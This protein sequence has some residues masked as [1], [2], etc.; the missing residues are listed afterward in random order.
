MR[1]SLLLACAAC[2]GPSIQNPAPNPTP[3]PGPAPASSPAALP[4]LAIVSSAELVAPG[5]VS[6][7][8]VEIRLAASPDGNTLLWG[9]TDRP[10]GPGGWDIW[11][12][13]R[14][15]AT[16]SAPVPVAF[17]SDANDFDPAFSG[18]GRWVYFFSNRAGGFGGD[19]LY[20]AAVTRDGFGPAQHL[21]PEINTAG[22]EWAPS[23]S[24][25]GTRLMFASNRPGAKHDLFI[26]R[27]VGD[28]FAP[29]EP[30]P[31]QVNAPATDEFDATFLSDGS[32]IV[33]ARSTDVDNDPIALYFAA[34]GPDGYTAP[35]PLPASVNV[36]AGY[37]LGPSSAGDAL[38]FSGKRPEA[39]AGKLDIYRVRYT[40]APPATSR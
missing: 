18:D 29:A 31:G 26:A 35:T 32:S 3:R 27:A 33:F 2:G 17:D 10:G 28:G 5:I 38:Y 36:A 7:E 4:A 15:G 14:T 11:S 20:R 21:G 34:L 37:T 13:R 30:L 8:H 22:N 19:D 25:D 24:R 23:P 16:W 6:S 39:S 12:T 9:S 1:T 40:L